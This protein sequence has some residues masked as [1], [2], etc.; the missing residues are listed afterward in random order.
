[1][2]EDAEERSYVVVVWPSLRSSENQD[3]PNAYGPMTLRDAREA[4]ESVLRGT[5]D[6]GI[7]IARLHEVRDLFVRHPLP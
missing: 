3:V 6:V 7:E 2:I 1:M 4:Q 5:P